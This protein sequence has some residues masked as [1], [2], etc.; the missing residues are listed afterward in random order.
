MPVLKIALF[1]SFCVQYEEQVLDHLES[2]KALELFC[3]LL[4]YRY[5]RHSRERL[6][7][8]LW[9]DSSTA[10]S[11]K[12]L[13]QTLWQLQTALDSIAAPNRSRLLVIEPDWIS[14][15]GHSE[16]ALDVETFEHSYE[17][18]SR[19]SSQDLNSR[20]IEF[21]W[22]AVK[23]Y[24]GNL[25]EGWCQ[26]WCLFERE[27]LQN[28]Y[29]FMVDKLVDYCEA[30]QDYETGL[31]Y[32]SRLLEF[33]PARE[34][35]HRRLMRLLYLAGDRTTALR[36]YERCVIA[37]DKEL[38]VRPS[39]R[40]VA[41]YEQIRA[42]ELSGPATFLGNGFPDGQRSFLLNLLCRLRELRAALPDIEHSIQDNIQAI[43]QTISTYR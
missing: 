18:L 3:Y 9:G 42:G 15:N 20:N 16:V 14:V 40:T 32:A 39:E 17:Q 10:Q 5:R 30:N 2:R 36:Q 33:D 8:L 28:M 13:R 7:T 43:E 27:R 29:L 1:G 26:E 25:L 6:A 12:Y 24:R 31:A 4:L 35:T 22:E 34:R 19:L 11:K 38:G 37:L 23:L 41:L 21:L